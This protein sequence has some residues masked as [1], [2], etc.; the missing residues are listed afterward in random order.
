MSREYGP[1]PQ[2]PEHRQMLTHSNELTTAL[3]TDAQLDTR[4]VLTGLE[5]VDL[6]AQAACYIDARKERVVEVTQIDRHR[7]RADLTD[8]IL[9]ADTENRLQPP[10]DKAQR[11]V[12]EVQRDASQRFTELIGDRLTRRVSG[13]S[14]LASDYQL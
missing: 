9:T 2:S 8:R 11:Q 13:T 10:L 12:L 5:L 4:L 1:L 3:A 14:L 6:F 7:S